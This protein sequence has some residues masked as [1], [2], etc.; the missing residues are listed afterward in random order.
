MRLHPLLAP[1][2]I[3]SPDEHTTIEP[4]GA[5]RSVQAA[6]LRLPAERLDAI[7]TPAGQLPL[8]RSEAGRLSFLI[9]A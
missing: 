3:A 6:D 4:S 9:V 1:A 5:V 7:W 8:Y 2:V